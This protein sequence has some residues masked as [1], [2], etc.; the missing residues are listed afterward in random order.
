ME[1]EEQVAI[2]LGAVTP[3]RD[4]RLAIKGFSGEPGASYAK[5]IVRS[6]D[7]SQLVRIELGGTAATDYGVSLRLDEVPPPSRRQDGPA[8]TGR[9]RVL[10][11]V[12]PDDGEG[13]R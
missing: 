9:G 1:T 4:L 11:T 8:P 6:G 13:A 12:L 10:V 7:E 3:W 2:V 5:V